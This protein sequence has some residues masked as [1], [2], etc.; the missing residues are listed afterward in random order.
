ML[1]R[2]AGIRREGVPYVRIDAKPCAEVVNATDQRARLVDFAV[3]V[4]VQLLTHAIRV[5]VGKR[6]TGVQPIHMA[7]ARATGGAGERRATGYG[8]PQLVR[9]PAVRY[10]SGLL[11]RLAVNY[12]AVYWRHFQCAP[13]RSGYLDDAMPLRQH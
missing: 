8:S 6:G 4:A 9:M 2:G 13:R 10:A 12:Q 3:A 5:R 11:I 1:K 7:T